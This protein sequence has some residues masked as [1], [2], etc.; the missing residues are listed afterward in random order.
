MDLLNSSQFYE[1][2]QASRASLELIELAFFDSTMISQLYFPETNKLGVYLPLL[3]PIWLP[4]LFS[5]TKLAKDLF[6]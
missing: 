6:K 1:A 5:I 4:V 3:L 2:Y